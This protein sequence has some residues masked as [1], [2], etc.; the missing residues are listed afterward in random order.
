MCRLLWCSVGRR[1]RLAERKIATSKFEFGPGPFRA[2]NPTTPRLLPLTRHKVASTIPQIL[3]DQ[4]A[5]FS[6]Y[7]T[8]R[9]RGFGV[10]AAVVLSWAAHSTRRTEDRSPKVPGRSRA[11]NPTKP[12]LLPLNEPE[13][14][15]NNPQSRLTEA[16]P[17]SMYVTP[18]ACVGSA[19]RALWCPVGRRNVEIREPKV[20]TSKSEFKPSQ[21]GAPNPT[22]PQLLPLTIRKVTRDNPE[23][24]LT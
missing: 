6:V 21:F 2:P 15:R 3:R 7:V 16:V 10:Q 12:Q 14:D 4:A 23:G 19:C 11:L 9:A 18:R 22:T 8:P 17:F 1:T 5:H 24:Y 13:V 20:A